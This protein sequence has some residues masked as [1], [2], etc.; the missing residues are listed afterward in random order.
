MGHRLVDTVLRY[1]RFQDQLTYTSTMPADFSATLPNSA[2]MGDEI[3]NNLVGF[4]LGCNVAYN[5]D[6][7]CKGLPLFLTPKV[8][9]YNNYIDSTFQMQLG[10]HTTNGY[11]TYYSRNTIP[12]MPR[13]TFSH[14]SPRSTSEPNRPF[15]RNWSRRGWASA[16]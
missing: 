2:Y 5:L 15:T 10:D 11:S 12:S 6:N 13:L 7:Y 1:F 14:S 8:G 16:A 9:I 3:T 4:Q